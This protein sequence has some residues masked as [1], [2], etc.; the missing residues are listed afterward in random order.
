MSQRIGWSRILI[1]VLL[2]VVCAAV[3]N[4]AASRERKMA[5]IGAYSRALDASP[6][7]GETASVPPP[8]PTMAQ[9]SSPAPAAALNAAPP[10]KAFAPHPDRASVEIGTDDA[11][12]LFREK[13]LFLDA[14]RTTVY[15]D[16][17]IPGARSFPIWESDIAERV[18]PYTT[19]TA[20][21]SPSTIASRTL[22]NDSPTNSA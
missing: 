11:E 4:L 5:W 9:T 1:L 20:S 13:R 16:G 18:K 21:N 17:H 22:L 12:Q 8:A 10:A 3:S 7:A 6:A 14:R 15:A 19:A 2:A